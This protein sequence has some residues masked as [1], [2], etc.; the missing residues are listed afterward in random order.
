VRAVTRCHGTFSRNPTLIC[1]AM[2]DAA[3]STL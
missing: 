3:K 2:A 1:P